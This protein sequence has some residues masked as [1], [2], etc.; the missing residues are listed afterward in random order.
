MTLGFYQRKQQ[1]LQDLHLGSNDFS[2]KG[3]LDTP[4]IDLVGL[5]NR[6][7][8][9]VTTSSCSGRV[10]IYQKV[11]QVVD[12]SK[13]Y[14]AS[15]FYDKSDNTYQKVVSKEDTNTDVDSNGNK[16]N[17]IGN[18]NRWLLCEHRTVSVEEVCKIFDEISFLEN[19][20]GKNDYSLES[21]HNFVIT[22]RQ[23]PFILHVECRTLD[24]AELL[25]NL[26]RRVGFRESGILINH[27]S[28]SQKGSKI[29]AAIRTCTSVMEVPL[30][31]N[32]IQV[33]DRRGLGPLV[34]LANEKFEENLRRIK[35]LEKQIKD[36]MIFENP[37]GND[38]DHISTLIEKKEKLSLLK[39]Q[40]EIFVF[41]VID[42]SIN[43]KL[44]YGDIENFLDIEPVVTDVAISRMRHT[45]CTYENLLYIF[46][47]YGKDFCK[48]EN[49]KLND[50]L[51]LGGSSDGASSKGSLFLRHHITDDKTEQLYPCPREAHAAVV[52]SPEDLNMKRVASVEKNSN[53]VSRSVT[54]SPQMLIYGG[55]TNEGIALDDCWIFDIGRLVNFLYNM[56]NYAYIYIVYMNYLIYLSIYLS[57]Y[58]YIYI[59]ICVCVCV[60]VCVCFGIFILCKCQLVLCFI[61]FMYDISVR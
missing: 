12:H 11:K 32:G 45:S 42:G 52:F 58:I 17:H 7:P 26:G 43:S 20:E 4:I 50:V 59:Y 34:S 60:C 18:Q 38:N 61:H 36:N 13:L 14:T 25:V 15:N 44:E 1:I 16:Y 19:K 24:S 57:I 48:R 21:F 47:G 6:S 9:Y 5:L 31:I 46:G 30:Y 41:P 39:R 3:S 51:V 49:E 53:F 56:M 22:L 54:L 33:V 55:K 10:A 28:K 27:G 37:N 2:P 29:I 8:D 40:T 35:A 23:E